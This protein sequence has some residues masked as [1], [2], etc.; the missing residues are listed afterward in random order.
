M[1][2]RNIE[3]FFAERFLEI[4][5]FFCSVSDP[6][7]GNRAIPVSTAAKRRESQYFST[8]FY[9]NDLL[10]KLQEYTLI[11]VYWENYQQLF[12]FLHRYYTPCLKY[13][14]Y[15]DGLKRQLLLL[16]DFLYWSITIAWLSF[17]CSIKVRNLVTIRR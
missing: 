4:I 2:C 12:L 6:E 3:I 9:F 17:K 5:Y 16:L 10:R 11:S 8:N 14:I 7:Y 1:F 13:K 15:L